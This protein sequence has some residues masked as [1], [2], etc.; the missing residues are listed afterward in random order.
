MDVKSVPDDEFSVL[1]G[2]EFRMS[3]LEFQGSGVLK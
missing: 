1:A 3:G 2:L